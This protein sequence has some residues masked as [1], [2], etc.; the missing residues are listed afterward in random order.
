MQR[1]L[2][3]AILINFKNKKRQIYREIKIYQKFIELNYFEILKHF[4]E[5][6]VDLIKKNFFKAIN[7]IL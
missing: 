3:I 7:D 4:S 6:I 2:K 5:T 1:D